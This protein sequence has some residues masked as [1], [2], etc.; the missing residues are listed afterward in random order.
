MINRKG[1]TLVEVLVYI[2]LAAL[3]LAPVVM[4]VQNSSVNM[5]RDAGSAAM[6]MSGRELLDII[7]NDLKN[8]GYK[9]NPGDFKSHDSV[10]YIDT[11]AYRLYVKACNPTPPTPA[12]PATQYGPCPV[13]LDTVTGKFDLS[14]F[15][16]GN[17]IGGNYYDTLTVRVGRLNK[18]GGWDGIDTITYKVNNKRELTRSV[19]GRSSPAKETITL[20]RNVEALKFRYAT[21]DLTEWYDDFNVNDISQLKE[22][23]Y[24]R[25]IKV[26]IVLKDE[27][28]LSP[29]KMTSITLIKAGDGD[30][31]GLKM[32]RN[33]LALYGRHEIVVPVPN[34]GL[35]P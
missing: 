14:S 12:P 33:D 5:A 24:V 29:T 23:C 9:I 21:E 28:K 6:K 22:K 25:Y 27:K 11:A 4:L 15:M 8:T 20:A 31:V 2:V 1:M 35:F 16:P 10:S 13:R 7:Y 17:K 18:S 34:N 32:E 26:I 3:L 19:K 30:P